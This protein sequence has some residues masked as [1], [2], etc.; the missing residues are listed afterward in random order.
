MPV[1]AGGFALWLGV[2]L[3]GYAQTEVYGIAL[4]CFIVGIAVGVG[5]M[6][7]RGT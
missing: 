2:E 7:R 1:I 6:S 5:A 3:L 4:L